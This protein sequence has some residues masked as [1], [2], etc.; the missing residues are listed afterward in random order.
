MS[1]GGQTC[2]VIMPFAQTTSEHT[3]D[4]WTGHF[5]KFL[6]PLIEADM[7]WAGRRSTALRGDIVKEIISE[8]VTAPA[9]VA[10]LT[11]ANPNVYWELGV[12]Q[13]FRHGTITIAEIGTRLPFDI[14]G[15]GTLFY[16]PK[17][18]L[19]MEAFRRQFAAALSS[20]LSDPDRPD[21]HV[22]ETISGRG[23]IYELIRRD[24]ANRRI[25]AL[26]TEVRHNIGELSKIKKLVTTNRKKPASR[27]FHTN[28]LRVSC[29]ELLMTTRYVDQDKS[30]YKIVEAAFDICSSINTQIGLWEHSPEATE[31]WL[32]G[33]A[34]DKKLVALRDALKPLRST[35]AAQR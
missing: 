20:C 12:R 24:E 4:Y 16:H 29:C 19:K 25:D 1:Q 17:N 13:S 22:L 14:G 34:S 7:Q 15:K 2:F 31:Q 6:R 33:N 3:E 18:H 10:D 26:F 35:L 32:L 30:F 21:S 11:D 5:E 9:V 23:T 8:L 28:L 27:A